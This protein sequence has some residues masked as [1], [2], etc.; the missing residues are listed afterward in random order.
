M[1]FGVLG[2]LTVWSADGDQVRIPEAKVRALLADLLVHQG[3]PVTA[4]RLIDDLWGEHPPGKPAGALRV[5]VSQLRRVLEEAVPGGRE[6]LAFRQPGYLL[7]GASD[8]DRFRELL[9]LARASDDPRIKAGLLG[10][11]LA[12]WRGPAFADFRDEEFVRP[13][14]VRLEEQ[15]LVALE[16]Q[17]Q[18]R[19]ELGEHGALAAELADLVADHPLRERLRGLH[20]RALYLAGRQS[21]ALDSYTALRDLLRDELGL[22][23]SPELAELHQLILAQDPSLG[24]G[25]RPRSNLPAPVNE[26]IGREAALAE[27][28]ELIKAHRLVTLTGPGG[29]GKTRLALEAASEADFPDGVWLV[30]LAAIDQP[31][32]MGIVHAV[33]GALGIRDDSTGKTSPSSGG[34]R[35]SDWLGDKRLLIVLDNCEHV[36]EV[37]AHTVE[38]LL[39]GAPGVRFL[40][41]SQEPLN[42]T[43]ECLWPVS[44]LDLDDDGA[45]VRLFAA[46]APGLVLDDDNRRIVGEICRRLDGIPLAIELAA[47]RTR[48]LSPRQ[49]L[50]RL[51][52]RFRLLAAGKRDAPARQQTLRAMIDWSWELASDDERVV[53]RRLAVHADS[54]TLEAAEA[55]CAAP[56]LDV[57]DLLARLIDRS[58]VVKLPPA[59]GREPR[60]RVLESVAAYC[61]ERLREA[62]EVDEVRLRHLRYYTELAERAEAGL[63]GHGQS[64]WLAALDAESANVV[65]ALEWAAAH[66]TQE[67]ALRL[68]NAMA[69]HWHLRGRFESGFRFFDLALSAPGEAGAG[70]PPV[71]GQAAG[72]AWSAPA[73]A[74]A[75][76]RSVLGQVAGGG[77]LASGQAAGEGRSAPAQTPAEPPPVTGQVP[78]DVLS[79]SGQAAGEAWSAPAQAPVEVPSGPGQAPAEMRAEAMAWRAGLMLQFSG[80]DVTVVDALGALG[81]IPDER[82]RARLT[83]YLAAGM[84]GRGDLVMSE[85]LVRESLETFEAIGDEWGIAAALGLR[86]GQCL[87]QGDMAGAHDDARRSAEIFERLGDPSG[88]LTATGELAKLALIAADYDQAAVRYQQALEAAEE[89]GSWIEVSHSLAGLGRIALLRGEYGQA[90]E[91]HERAAR[92]AA[93]QSNPFAGHFAEIGLALSARRQGRLDD[94]ERYLRR[95]LEWLEMIDGAPGSALCLAELGFVAELRGHAEEAMKLHLAGYEQARETGDPRAVALAQEGLAGAETLAGNHRMAARLLGAAA[96]ARA[97]VGVPLPPAERADVDRISAALRAALGEA[98]F[99][100]EF[101]VG[102]EGEISPLGG[103]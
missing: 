62:G 88:V 25:A 91:L 3:R 90:D 21:E 79:G 29:V 11:A 41:T 52:D 76:V 96:R 1:R 72:E 51:D 47:T 103:A 5:K 73:Q 15:R 10:D 85:R 28:R 93:E 63:R 26:L 44:P 46:R 71:S 20:I 59:E 24:P 35:M 64:E 67:E 86:S 53:L 4:D 16:E 78:A 17:A 97:G 58:L 74:P 33:A 65:S 31:S 8:A 95:W 32:K 69:W 49:L 66:R 57:L 34:C 37:V 38:Q 48:A 30:E 84:W 94:A 92:L 7:E 77:L 22:D 70:A 100:A 27:V 87:L 99:E 40:A 36:I 56:G 13:A 14:V 89:L 55:V 9:D 19:L 18:A 75:E 82:R 60:Y 81:Q 101:E 45:A 6:Q 83:W 61:D 23:P 42:L 98:E 43:G 54:C 80:C 12:L 68:V 102:M 50:E 39:R 2:P